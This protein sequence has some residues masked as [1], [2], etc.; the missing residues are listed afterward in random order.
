MFTIAHNSHVERTPKKDHLGTAASAVPRAKP[1]AVDVGVPPV[2]RTLLSVALHFARVGRTL[3]SV[4]LH[5]ARVG[6][7][8]LSDA[9][10]FD[11][12]FA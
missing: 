1:R 11:F 9:F 2:G 6:R 8:L 7:T 5:F 10:D 3:L 12:D 4:A